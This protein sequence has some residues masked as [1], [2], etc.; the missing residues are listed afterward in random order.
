MLGPIISENDPPFFAPWVTLAHQ[1]WKKIWSPGS[2]D[3]G[4]NHALSWKR[5]NMNYMEGF[6]YHSKIGIMALVNFGRKKIWTYIKIGKNYKHPPPPLQTL[7]W[8]YCF[9]VVRPSVTFCFLNIL[10]SNCWIFIKP[11]KHIHIC[12]TNTLNKKV[13]EGANSIR[14]ISICSSKWICI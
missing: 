9:Q 13:R 10:K 6:S 11:C 7:W 14:V 8:V 2:C 5:Q 3:K 12:K 4:I 1:S